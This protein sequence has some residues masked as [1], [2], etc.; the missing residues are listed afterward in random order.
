MSFEAG[1]DRW[2][3]RVL[4]GRYRIDALIARGG[5]GAVYRATQLAIE[6]PVAVKLLHQARLESDHHAARFRQEARALAQL[7]HPRVVQVFDF[8]TCPDEDAL[9]LVM[10]LLDGRTL[11]RELAAHGPLDPERA[12][13]LGLAVLEALAEAHAHGIVHRDL[14]PDNLVL[15]RRA[16]RDEVKLV[17]FG[18]AKLAGIEM[19]D[20]NITRTGM[21]VGSPRYLAPEQACDLPVTDRTDIYSLGAVLYEAVVGRP[22]FTRKS[23]TEYLT[24]HL[25]DPP[26]PP[27]ADRPP[28][29]T[30]LLRTLM[31]FM[32]KDP[33]ERPSAAQAAALLE[34]C[35]A[36]SATPTP[37]RL[38]PRPRR[39]PPPLLGRAHELAAFERLL[40]D[41]DALRYL[42]FYGPGGIG[43]TTLVSACCERARA[44]GLTVTWLDA[45]ELP[46]LG[47]LLAVAFAP[48]LAAP[49]DLLVIDRIER[50]AGM[51]DALRDGILSA[52]PERT[53]VLVAGR[54]ALG[55][56]R[57]PRLAG[58]VSELELDRL[59][60][61]DAC[62]LLS[63]QGVPERLH[64]AASDE[65]RG[66]PLTLALLGARLATPD[67]TFETL[68]ALSTGQPL[69]D[70]LARE[71]IDQAPSDAHLRGLL[72]A[73]LM[74]RLTDDDLASVLPREDVAPVRAWLSQLACA[75]MRMD[76]IEL[77]DLT[78]R[79]FVLE[80]RRQSPARL[81]ELIE[82]LGQR[83]LDRLRTA[84]PESYRE[85][86]VDTGYVIGQLF[87]MPFD[88]IDPSDLPPL[89]P[90]AD[91]HWPGIE[92]LLERFEGPRAVEIL[93]AWRGPHCHAV[94]VVDDGVVL[95]FAAA[96]RLDTAPA[97]L[98]ALDPGTREL[99]RELF[100]E[101]GLSRALPTLY[102]RF[103]AGPNHHMPSRAQT[104]IFFYFI[105]LAT[106][107]NKLGA[108]VSAHHPP[109][110]WQRLASTSAHEMFTGAGFTLD[111]R[112]FL[113][114]GR[115]FSGLDRRAWLLSHFQA[116]FDAR[117]A[118]AAMLTP[119]AEPAG[120]RGARAF[121]AALEALT[122]D[123]VHAGRWLPETHEERAA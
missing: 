83:A 72:A 57:H 12:I 44:R 33:S 56:D 4:D 89:L 25:E 119:N 59:S 74:R 68:R 93:R 53:R 5:F 111:G 123:D 39:E 50:A 67:A 28:L 118:L 115:D 70:V 29:D 2:V 88:P 107:L 120:E 3:G 76:G 105:T 78:R 87:N 8:G 91:E 64:L 49:P 109:D 90:A 100:D 116:M 61:A 26:D 23:V 95:G 79:M 81:L 15:E 96:L 52:L 99:A 45:A 117:H 20:P 17:D 104:Q 40:D 62:A 22:V 55:W 30:R 84:P 42:A 54:R 14:K 7:R 92:A 101:R 1:P 112:A 18:I 110:Y 21:L 37:S 6:R 41:D 121:D 86:L 16:D 46:N 63:R 9:Y 27:P 69:L 60:T 113:P 43:K 34:A 24:A 85:R 77:H 71:L 66:H 103:W 65:S 122:A 11:A 36:T 102:F 98:I 31:R 35:R 10:E 106:S 51:L 97:E 80:A 73:S 47:Q 108:L 13:D 38:T 94:A 48:V 19:R 82:L 114:F 58:V 75:R 32:A